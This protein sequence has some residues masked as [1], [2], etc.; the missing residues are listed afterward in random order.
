VST[1][2]RISQDPFLEKG[3][4]TEPGYQCS[5]LRLTREISVFKKSYLSPRCHNPER[6]GKY[7]LCPTQWT[8]KNLEESNSQG[9]LPHVRTWG[10]S[11]WSEGTQKRKPDSWVSVGALRKDTVP[12]WHI[13]QGGLSWL[14]LHVDLAGPHAQSCG[15]TRASVKVFYRC[16]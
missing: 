15:Q 5:T 8:W 1:T 14:M 6:P 13:M 10:I 12:S 4:H 9:F 3:Q 2:A 16:D 7:P 11:A